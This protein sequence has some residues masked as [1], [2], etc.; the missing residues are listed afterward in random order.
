MTGIKACV[1]DAYGDRVLWRNR[2]G[3]APER[4]IEQPDRELRS[5]A[6]LPEIIGVG[7]TG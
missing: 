4:I 6:V 5:L 1:F 7:I 2:F 3:Q